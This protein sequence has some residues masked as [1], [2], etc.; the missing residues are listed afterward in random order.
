MA[1]HSD[2]VTRVVFSPKCIWQT[3]FVNAVSGL[4]V[5]MG[6]SNLFGLGI[7]S[8]LIGLLDRKSQ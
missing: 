8:P 5:F 1:V 4:R 6:D 2:A 7:E 3:G